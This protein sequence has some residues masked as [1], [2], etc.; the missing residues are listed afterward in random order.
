M[1]VQP[2]PIDGWIKLMS[3]VQGRDKTYR[4]V[5]YVTRMLAAILN[6]YSGSRSSPSFKAVILKLTLISQTLG[7]ARKRTPQPHF[8]IYSFL[9]FSI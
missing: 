2:L 3:N 1:Q 8:K 6:Q 9:L 4:T 5:Q 7:L